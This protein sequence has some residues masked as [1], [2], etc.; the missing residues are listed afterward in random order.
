MFFCY[1]NK[2]IYPIYLSNQNFDDSMDLLL[3]SNN[4]VS[5]YVYIK[6]FNRLM[7]N[8]TKHKDKKYFCKSCLQCLSSESVLN[9]HKEDCLMINGQ[10]NVKS[11]KG[12][13]KFSNYSRQIPVPYKIFA[14]FE[15]ILK[16]IDIDI[17][18]DDIS[19]TKKYQD[20]VPCSFAYKVVCID[21]KYSKQIVLHRGKAAVNKFSKLILNEYNYCKKV[22][23]KHFDKNLTMTAEENEKFEMTNICWICNKFI[24][25]CDNKVR[26]HCHITGRYR[27]AAHWSCNINLKISNIKKAVPV[28]FHNLEGYGSHL[29]FKEFSKFNCKISVTK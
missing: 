28:I 1:E 13:I 25:I 3:I 7:F 10:Q 17:S 6:D 15:C 16:D 9:E 4:F 12:F 11:E 27:R 21:N 5:H 26:D 24:D 8:K 2:A 29:I 18:N 20:H 22:I 14:D 23:K 19:Y